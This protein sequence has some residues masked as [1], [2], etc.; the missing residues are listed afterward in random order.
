METNVTRPAFFQSLVFKWTATLLLTSLIGVALA[1]VLAYRTT[2]T[3]FDRLRGDQALDGFVAAVT[4]YYQAQGDWAGVAEWVRA[5]GGPVDEPWRPQPPELFALADGRGRVVV[6]VGPLRAGQTAPAEMLM[7]G[8]PVVVDGQT[9][10]TVVVVVRLPDLDPREQRYLDNTNR[11]LIVGAVAAMAAALIIGLLL[12][13]QFLQPLSALTEAI[14]AMRMGDLDQRVE[15]GAGD[16]LGLLA[17]TFNEMTADLHRA[18]QLRQQMTADIAHD[19]RTPLTVISGYLEGMQDGTLAATPERFGIMNEE[20]GRLLRL[21]D[22]L[23]T[24]SLADAGE[25]RLLRAPTAPAELLG[26]VAAAFAAQ[27][28]SAGVVL[29]VEVDPATP[30]IDTDEARMVQ[31]LGNLVSN[32]LRYTPV[33]GQVVLRAKSIPGGVCLQVQDTGAGIA[34]EDLPNVFERFY[35][36]DLARED[37]GDENRAGSGLGLAIAKSIVAAHGGRIYAESMVGQGTTMTVE[38]EYGA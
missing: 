28:E 34:P 21:V 37:N 7:A 3:E 4:R 18:N 8:T 10:G 27:A 30:E 19:L 9:V 22:D 13:R 33:G 29:G 26:R 11:A 32:A 16:E 1:G 38:L 6:G 14:T 12:S 24:L 23:R 5:E 35:R 2:V 31:V 20:V 25:L 36:A 15:I 17:Q